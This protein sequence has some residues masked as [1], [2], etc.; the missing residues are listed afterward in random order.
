M[1]EKIGLFARGIFSYERPA[2]SLSVEKLNLSVSTGSKVRGSFIVSSKG[3]APFKGIAFCD[4]S[5]LTFD[6]PSFCGKENTLTFTIDAT[7]L[8]AGDKLKG[9]IV[10][11]TELGEAHIPFNCLVSSLSCTSSLGPVSDI[12]QFAN[13]A[14]TD[15]TEAKNLFKSDI[16]SSVFSK[17]SKK[18]ELAIRALKG[19]NNISLAVEEFLIALRKKHVVS[20][21]VDRNEIEFDSPEESEGG[22]MLTLTKDS[23]GYVQ[24]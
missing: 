23:W 5:L 24:L 3:S 18:A 1:K 11:V 4:E 19:C 16:F 2:L 21:S 17:A 22:C 12:F 14:Q 7:H 6:D 10:L 20:V 15:W 13:L 9:N 8:D